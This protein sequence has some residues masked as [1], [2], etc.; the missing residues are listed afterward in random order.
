MRACAGCRL[1]AVSASSLEHETRFYISQGFQDFVSKPYD[2]E[3][4]YAALAEHAGCGSM[5]AQARR[6]ACRG[7][8]AAA[9]P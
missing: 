2:F 6:G 4:I 9:A 1:I 8:G 5:P 7:D 3:S